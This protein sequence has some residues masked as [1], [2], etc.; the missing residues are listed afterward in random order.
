MKAGLKTKEAMINEPIHIVVTGHPVAKARARASVVPRKGGGFVTDKTGRPL[1]HHHTPEKTRKWESEARE[2]A[3]HEMGQDQPIAA[4]VF[5]TVTAFFAPAQ[6]W[7]NWKRD[8][9]LAG[10][11]G[12]TSKPDADNILKAA[13]DALNGI[14]WLDDSQVIQT[15]VAKAYSHRPRVHITVRVMDHISPSSISSKKQL[16]IDNAER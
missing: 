1:L 6:S 2:L 15:Q 12:H 8:A 14:V 9:A 7:P 10:M 4:P 16:V 3:R 13:K 5:L 11:I